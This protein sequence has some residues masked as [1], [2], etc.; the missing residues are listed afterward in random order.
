MK[1]ITTDLR[2][3]AIIS[4]TLVLP[5]AI[6][7]SLFNTV[8]KQNAPGLIVLFGLLWLV[9]MAFIV[10][11]VPLVRTVRAG[12]SIMVN[13]INLFFRVAFL[14]LMAMTWGGIL[15]DQIPCFIGVPNCD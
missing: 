15:L 7:E 12:N 8:N 9:S 14:A 11:L 10:V 6:L 5:F 13:P 4:F 1:T 3:A 2:L